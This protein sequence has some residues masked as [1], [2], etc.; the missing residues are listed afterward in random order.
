MLCRRP[1]LS[2]P[3]KTNWACEGNVQKREACGPVRSISV[4]DRPQQSKVLQL[5]KETGEKLTY[6][7]QNLT[8]AYS[9]S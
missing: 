5:I 4:G 9:N 1:S 3:V 7:S 6:L 2:I 8:K